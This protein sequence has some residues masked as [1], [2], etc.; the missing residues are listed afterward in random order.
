M[1]RLISGLSAL[2]IAAALA[3]MGAFAADEET[4]TLNKDNL[5]DGMTVTYNA[6]RNSPEFLITIPASVDL[7]AEKDE[8]RTATITAE[9]VY[10][11]TTKHKAINVTLDSAEY[12]NTGDSTFIAKTEKGDSAVEYTIGKGEATSGVKVGDVVATFANNPDTEAE[13]D[14]QTATLSFSEPTGATYAGTHTEVLTFGVSVENAVNNPYAASKIGDVVTFGSYSWYIIGKSDDGV[15]LLMKD[16]L[17]NKAYN[18]DWSDCTWETCSLRTYLN[19][20]FY[21]S[22]SAEDKAKIALTSNTNPKN[23]DYSTSGGNDTEDYIY[24]LSISEANALDSSIRNDGSWWWLRS[25][26]YDSDGAAFVDEVG[27]VR[28]FGYGVGNEYGVRP[29]LNLKFE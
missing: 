1:K 14:V 21:N 22:F 25:P 4:K 27:D 2:A 16:N 6:P 19:G 3:P 11:D 7:G 28:T 12:V 13:K 29:A 18:N 8:D 15:T 10:L 20:D 24:L 5:S 26:G 23:P 17:M 9:D